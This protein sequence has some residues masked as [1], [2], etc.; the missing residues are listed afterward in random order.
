M[1]QWDTS[2]LLWD[3]C[4]MCDSGHVIAIV[5]EPGDWTFFLHTPQRGRMLCWN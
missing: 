3:C 5:I 4:P 2:F 1:N